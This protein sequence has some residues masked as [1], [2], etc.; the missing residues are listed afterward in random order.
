MVKEDISKYHTIYNV[1]ACDTKI[2]IPTNDTDAWFL[3]KDHNWIY[4]RLLLAQMQNIECAPMPVEPIKY[5]VILKPII[6]LYGM[7]LNITKINSDGE[8]QEKWGDN[9]FWMEFL[10]GRHLSVD[11]LMINGKIQWYAAFE[12]HKLENNLGYFKYWETIETK[13]CA[14]AMI[15]IDRLT[16]YTGCVNLEIIGDRVIEGHLRMGDINKI[17]KIN[18][19]KKIIKIYSQSKCH[20]PKSVP[21][22]FLFPIWINKDFDILKKLDRNIIHSICEKAYAYQIDSGNEACPSYLRRI[23]MISVFDYDTGIEVTSNIYSYIYSL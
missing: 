6:N 17:P 18:I 1:L 7:G 12:G 3:Y 9:N 5:P 10:E 4:N 15:I 20:F 21:K 19:M 8:F 16:K 14:N 22:I 13:L 2:I 23:M 11:I